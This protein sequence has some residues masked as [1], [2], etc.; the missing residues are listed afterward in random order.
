[1]LK[2]GGF[3]MNDFQLQAQVPAQPRLYR[4]VL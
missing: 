3:T 2:A 4:E 1:M